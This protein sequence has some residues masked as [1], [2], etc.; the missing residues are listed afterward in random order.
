MTE[1]VIAV[2]DAR[3]RVLKSNKMTGVSVQGA[4][5]MIPAGADFN[6]QVLHTTSEAYVK[7][8]AAVLQ[9]I[10]TQYGYAVYELDLLDASGTK[11]HALN[12]EVVV[13]LPIPEG[14]TLSTGQ[15][16]GVYRL[17]DD[18]TLTKCAAETKDGTVTFRTNH[19]STYIF[20]IEKQASV[21][22][23]SDS[24]TVAISVILL[25]IAFCMVAAGV[26]GR[27]KYARIRK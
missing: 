3:M 9:H 12:G 18:G 25:C 17:K 13:Q 21:P 10:P 27:G 15:T 14:L 20:A 1:E 24:N 7:A 22:N 5:G 4:E 2:G 26:Y 6:V 23:T 16:I 11:M 19:F 8:T